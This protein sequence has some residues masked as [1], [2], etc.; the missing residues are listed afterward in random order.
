M[1][2]FF[3]ITAVV[4]VVS[5]TL[6][7]KTSAQETG[8]LPEC[9]FIYMRDGQTYYQGEET[10]LK[11]VNYLISMHLAENGELIVGPHSNYRT[12]SSLSYPTTQE[13]ASNFLR[14]HFKMIKD[15]GFNSIR[16]MN[17]SVVPRWNTGFLAIRMWLRYDM[18]FSE[19]NK[20]RRDTDIAYH[21]YLHYE[22]ISDNGLSYYKQA[23]HIVLD[24]A[25]EYD[26]KIVW[27][28]GAEAR[29]VE[30]ATLS[31]NLHKRYNSLFNHYDNSKTVEYC[32][33]LAEIST[34]FK[35]HPALFAYDIC[36]EGE[37]FENEGMPGGEFVNSVSMADNVKVINE[38]I[39]SNT[40]NQYTT[41]GL[42]SL[43][44]FFKLGVKPFSF[45]DI[46]SF[47]SYNSERFNGLGLDYGEPVNLGLFYFNKTVT[48]PWMIG[49]NGI[50]TAAQTGFGEATE[51]N[52]IV[53][54]TNQTLEAQSIMEFSSRCGSLGYSYWQFRNEREWQNFG[55]I[56]GAWSATDYQYGE[57][58]N[59][60]YPINF[61]YKEIVNP[62]NTSLFSTFNVQADGCV[63]N[64]NHYYDILCTPPDPENEGNNSQ[65]WDGSVV[66]GE[67]AVM[68]AI[69]KIRIEAVDYYTFTKSDGTFSLT[70]PTPKLNPGPNL[71]EITVT[72][73]GYDNDTRSNVGSNG[74]VSSAFQINKVVYPSKPTYTNNYVV[75]EGESKTISEQTMIT[76]HVYVHAGGELTINCSVFFNDNTQLIVNPGGKLILEDG[77]VLTAIHHAWFG[78]VLNG[79]ETENRPE[80]VSSGNTVIAK[81][82][83]GIY[84]YLNPVGITAFSSVTID[85]NGTKFINNYKDVFINRNTDNILNFKNCDFIITE[86]ALEQFS[87][88]DN[89]DEF[90]EI[91]YS[92]HAKFVNCHFADNRNYSSSVPEKVGI[93]TINLKKLEVLPDP[94]MGARKSTF[95]NL[96]YAIKA[97]SGWGGELNIRN[98]EFTTVRGVYVESYA[99]FEPVVIVNSTF[100]ILDYAGGDKEDELPG[101]EEDENYYRPYG[102]YLDN[103]CDGY[104]I[105]G[106]IFKSENE[107]PDDKYGLIANSNGQL[108][109]TFYRNR[110]YNLENAVQAIGLNRSMNT[111]NLEGLQVLCNKFYN[112]KTDVF[113][114]S[115]IP[116]GG[117]AK[118]Q[119][120][121]TAPASNLFTSGAVLCN[122]KNEL[123]QI[124][125]FLRDPNDSYF[126]PLE[127]PQEVE[128]NFNPIFIIYG[129]SFD[130]VCPNYSLNLPDHIVVDEMYENLES[131]VILESS[132]TSMLDDIV[133]GGN[134]GQVISDIIHLDD[135]SA[136]VTYYDL[137]YKSPYLSDTVLK[138]VS[139]KEAGLTVPMIRDILVANPQAAKNSDVKKLLKDRNNQ[140]PDYMLEQ[141]EAGETYISAKENLEIQRSDQR[142]IYDKSLMK[143]IGYYY[144]LEDSL[145]YA[146]DSIV[147]LL[148][149]RNE[150]PYYF[151]L[152]GY[153]FDKLRYPEA[154]ETL[155][156]MY[157]VCELTD[158]EAAEVQ[159]LIS[160]ITFYKNLLKVCK[161]DLYNLND[162]YI[163]QLEV[164][165]DKG[166][167]GG[168]KAH[169]IL[170]LND[171]SDYKEIVYK[172]EEVIALRNTEHKYF[173]DANP[174]FSVYPNPAKEHINVEYKLIE[175]KG[176]LQFVITDV[177]GQIV[178]QKQL[179]NLQDIVIVKISDLPKGTYNCSLY[180][181][182]K[183]EFNE[184]LVI[185]NQ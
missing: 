42:F 17:A 107:L 31:N 44:S 4:A 58:G 176:V 67:G 135:N 21:D 22:S 147:S 132:I 144:E 45:C 146:E 62:P 175:Q 90:I 66:D 137:M 180:N 89:C 94:L 32:N 83:I 79:N 171:A 81:A 19:A 169:V 77:A 6:L 20:V 12:Y 86:D 80:V 121:L 41:V 47:H 178:L 174:A 14:A 145:P 24:I 40:P 154:I 157:A 119:G 55:L 1:K 161:G 104:K 10:F 181:G 96:Y 99:S 84:N 37:S 11:T 57:N 128:G 149:R 2:R 159:D 133:D 7:G 103:I 129:E 156:S 91:N 155:N 150:A 138:N 122:Y 165:E 88:G 182:S 43:N 59:E 114:N 85:L 134:T 139:K 15:M 183:L 115:E 166:G 69:V 5:L 49:E 179:F 61:A 123:S 51:T 39:K 108:S 25:Q 184:K 118:N 141:I 27:V 52:N 93:E 71:A 162:F 126:N 82:H 56:K 92:D 70:T 110:F 97:T 60:T 130:E 30:E 13:E 160:F 120:S 124:D 50:E 111:S 46:I 117:I 127:I 95:T 131:S 148:K 9:P 113:V 63:F 112:T 18:Y 105:E 64:T 140:L 16:I 3:R 163:E 26:L 72:K 53:S 29:Y 143:L 102:V 164:F 78:I 100:N 177:K 185:S 35:S 74:I 87:V 38:S 36:N 33:F 65:Y 98:C 168:A 167:R 28:T 142:A 173:N 170:L 54:E 152:A 109:N 136:W 23:M 76:G 68:D 116:Y 125:Y 48:A 153:Y 151:E 158:M 172:P 106:N 34:E 75:N 8:V 101:G 73:Y